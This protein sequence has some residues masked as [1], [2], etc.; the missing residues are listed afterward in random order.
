MDSTDDRPLSVLVVDQGGGL[1]SAARRLDAKLQLVQKLDRALAL[2]LK[3]RHDVALVGSDLGGERRGSDL[4]AEAVRL[5]CRVPLILVCPVL[6]ESCGEAALQAGAVACADLSRAEQGDLARAVAFAH[7]NRTNAER[8]RARFLDDLAS[9]LAHEAK[10]A[11]AGVGGAVQVVS[12]HLPPDSED[13]L[14]CEEIRE[15]LDEFT[16]TIDSLISLL[17]PFRRLALARVRVG[18]LLRDAAARVPGARLEVGGEDLTVEGDPRLLARLFTALI[19]N[20]AEA[21]EGEGV[22]SVS[23][24][25]E[26]GGVIVEVRDSGPGAPVGELGRLLEP[27]HTTKRRHAGLGLPLAR[28]IAEAH[29]GTLDL[30][31]GEGGGLCVCV[32]LPGAD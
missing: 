30:A 3:Q 15:R 19:R 5:G 22:I 31:P 27:F 12:D 8:R 28:R 18:E 32:R 11:L 29:G 16:D 23:Q 10:N 26:N 24:R 7:A 14:L 17:R 13:R 9:Y 20:A 6:A 25:L 21:A 1:A 2:L 4:I